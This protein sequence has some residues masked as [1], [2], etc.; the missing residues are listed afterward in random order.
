[1]RDTKLIDAYIAKETKDKKEK[2]LFK[3]LKKEVETG[4]NGTQEYVIKQGPNKDKI[5]K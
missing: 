3:I 5:A 2:E 4:A 1:M